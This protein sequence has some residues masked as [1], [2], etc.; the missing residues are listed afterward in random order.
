MDRALI[1]VTM[2]PNV[3]YVNVIPGDPLL[4][5]EF[6]GAPPVSSIPLVGQY[7]ITQTDFDYKN[8]RGFWAETN[9]RYFSTYKF[10]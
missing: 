6:A 2:A 8:K 4:W 5:T 10:P 1:Y 9:G 7:S 3:S